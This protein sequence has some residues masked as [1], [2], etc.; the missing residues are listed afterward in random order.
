MNSIND[1]ITNER[2]IFNPSITYLYSV[3]VAT[4]DILAKLR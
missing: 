2:T 1:R 3:K 4:L